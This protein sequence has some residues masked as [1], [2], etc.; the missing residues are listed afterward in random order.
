[1]KENSNELLLKAICFAAKQ[2]EGQNGKG[3]EKAPYISH[4]YRVVMILSHIFEVTDT[5]TLIVGVL[6]DTLEKSLTE[7]KDLKAQ[8][9]PSIADQVVLLSKDKRL[10]EKEGDHLYAKKLSKAPI[11]VK[12]IKLADM[13]DNLIEAVKLDDKTKNKKLNRIALYL[14][15][16][17]KNQN[18][19]LAKYTKFIESRLNQ[20]K[21][22]KPFS[23]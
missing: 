2:H 19:T 11:N 18:K 6:H 21:R 10:P 22:N 16:I 8:F 15:F 4:V 13:Y 5:V 12:I 9:G 7:Y 17:Q 1:M 14:K 3:N 20:A 23:I